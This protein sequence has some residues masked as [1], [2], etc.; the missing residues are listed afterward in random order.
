MIRRIAVGVLAV[1]LAACGEAFRA[2]RGQPKR[3]SSP[4]SR[5]VRGSRTRSRPTPSRPAR[6]PPRRSASLLHH[7][8]DAAAAAAGVPDARAEPRDGP[9]HGRARLAWRRRSR[10][11]R[12]R[13]DRGA[14]A[15]SSRGVR[16][17]RSGGPPREEAS[18]HAD[19]MVQW[20][21]H[22]RVRYEDMAAMSGMMQARYR[23]HL[24]LPGQHRRHLH[25]HPGRGADPLSRS[26]AHGRRDDRNR[27][28][29][30]PIRPSV[31]PGTA[32]HPEST[33]MH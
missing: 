16:R 13:H 27:R 3:S 31:P 2:T 25:V 8:Y 19:T 9:A 14:G 18:H 20:L 4:T 1:G 10:V 32:C 21:E 7:Q 26:R 33:G 5:W 12:C 17:N 24:R 22:Q 11:R 15:P 30:E 6:P 23:E 29:E 28:P